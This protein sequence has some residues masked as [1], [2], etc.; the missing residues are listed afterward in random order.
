[1]ISSS[2]NLD[3]RSYTS[4]EVCY[5]CSYSARWMLPC[6]FSMRVSFDSFDSMLFIIREFS[7]QRYG[8]SQGVIIC[9]GIT[10]M[11][12]QQRNYGSFHDTSSESVLVK[13]TVTRVSNTG[14]GSIIFMIRLTDTK[15][16][17]QI[18]ISH[19]LS[20]S[21]RPRR[22][23][24]EVLTLSAFSI[25]LRTYPRFV[26]ITCLAFGGEI[27]IFCWF[28]LLHISSAALVPVV[29]FNLSCTNREST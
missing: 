6:L 29:M 20:P 17:S 11:K 3:S 21:M 28:H 18:P 9:C 5:R 15:S 7:K 23:R 10:K 4:H 12:L 19:P 25:S 27:C 2:T 24:C 22:E 14:S 8:T 1:M 13:T 16:S 26:H